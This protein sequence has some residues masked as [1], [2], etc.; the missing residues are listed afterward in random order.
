[1]D[2]RIDELGERARWFLANFDEVDL[3][4]ICASHEASSNTREDA[5]SRVRAEVARWKLNT[6]EPQTM[7]ALD[8]IDRALHGP[9]PAHNAGPTVREAA[10]DDRA[11]WD[12]KHAGEGA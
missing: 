4:D 2:N 7:R 6:L 9:S 5:L 12:N 8:D 3:A 10:A 1:M 11:H